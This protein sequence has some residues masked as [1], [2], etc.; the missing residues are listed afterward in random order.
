MMLG[1]QLKLFLKLYY[2]PL[3]AMSELMDRG[4]W[5]FGVVAVIAISLALQF[6]VTAPRPSPLQDP[7]APQGAARNQ[8]ARPTTEREPARENEQFEEPASDHEAE[9]Y[10]QQPG[11]RVAFFSIAA[12]FFSPLANWMTV[13]ALALLYV[14]ATILAISLLEDVGSFGVAFNRDYGALLACTLTAWA[15]AH[16]P[17][18]I[19]GWVIVALQKWWLALFVAAIFAKLYFAVLM[20]CAL[21][22]VCGARY[23]RAIGA[24]SVSWVAMLLQSM[25]WFLASPFLLFFFWRYLSSEAAGLG[26]IFSGR[27][28]FRRHL[29]AAMLNPSDAEAR[30][31]LGL[32]YQQRRQYGEAKAYFKQAIEVNNRETDAHYQLGCMARMEGRL[33]EAIEHFNEVVTQDEKHAHN[34][35]WR[36]IG[37][38]YL[39]AAMVEDALAALEKFIERRPYDPEGL[40]HLGVTLQKLNRTNEAETMFK[41]CIEAAR[42]KLY[43]RGGQ[44]Q[45][46]GK[47]AE[48][49]LRLISTPAPTT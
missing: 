26:A 39:A 17:L 41:R 33:Q 1:E 10:L 22:R 12:R 43:D 36:E 25:L 24:I 29:D 13:L 6:A 11:G 15:A 37:A 45:R 20:V 9:V 4:R 18:L 3:T 34:E 46:W 38:T 42:T 2:Q 32:I 30:Y 44:S 8:T 21:R 27:Q 49:Q 40:F 35:V 23:A 47:Q 28:S 16:L 7:L 19:I 14:P 31:Q 5:F 48:K